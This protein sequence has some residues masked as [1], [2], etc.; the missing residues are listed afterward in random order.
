VTDWGL[1]FL[2]VIAAATLVTAIA[3]VGV[4]IAAG[5]AAKRAQRLMDRVEGELTPFF[6]HLNAVG[7]D[8][9]RAA[10]LAAA[11]VD[12]ADRVFADLVQRLEH[13]ISTVQTAVGGTA[14]EGAAVV[15]GVRAA[16]GVIREARARRARH[17]A[18][19]EDGLFI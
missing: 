18:E 17:R 2:G 16:L 8:A 1:V 4:F 3:Q 14:R 11:Q 13:T 9:A 15:A 5:M 12:R 10:A 19:E 6:G 7:R